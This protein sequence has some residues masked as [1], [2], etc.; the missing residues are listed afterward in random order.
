MT[1]GT[2]DLNRIH[3]LFEYTETVVAL[4]GLVSRLALINSGVVKVSITTIKS[5]IAGTG[6]GSVSN[7]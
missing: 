6:N 2:P 1:T 7:K 3:A 5:D 4:R